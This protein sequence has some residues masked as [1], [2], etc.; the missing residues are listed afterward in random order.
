[1]TQ[2]GYDTARAADP[3][4]AGITARARAVRVLCQVLGDRR[5]LSEALERQP[6]RLVDARDQ[7]LC[8]ELCFG[9]LRWLPRLQWLHRKL[10]DGNHHQDT[11]V[12]RCVLYT[13]LYQI[14]HLQVPDHAAVSTSVELCRTL[15]Q[16]RAA[17]LLN[18]LLRRYLREQE[19][20]QQRMV[21]HETAL[22]AHPRW[23]LE[24][25]RQAWPDDWQTLIVENNQR[26][27][28]YLR[29]N[30]LRK[31][32][33][34][35]LDMLDRTGIQ[36]SP[37][38]HTPSALRLTGALPVAQLPGFAQGQCAVQDGSA[39]LTAELLPV[40]AGA[41]ML[42]ACAAPGG[43]TGLFLERWPDMAALVAIDRQ[44]HRVAK[45]IGNLQRLGHLKPGYPASGQN[46]RLAILQADLRCPETWWDGEAFD[47]ILLDAPCSGSGIIRRQPDIKNL[48]RARQLRQLI[49]TQQQLLQTCWGLL[50][51]GGRLLYATCSVLPAENSAQVAW[52]SGQQP[53]CVLQPIQAPWGRDTGFGTQLMTGHQGMDG[54]FYALLGKVPTGQTAA[55]PV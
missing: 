11:L 38:R 22:H 46:Q 3:Q 48:R 24:T 34:A 49:N 23:W 40:P 2:P 16:P 18:A 52:F 19:T 9:V 37:C 43:K 32:R 31:S 6:D 15:D 41:R 53:D 4:Q 13:G 8:K 51:P 7:A 36:A 10:R 5:K 35:F 28:L 33:P 1:M 17:K 29:V 20:M 42:D 30:C 26:P 21:Q 47:V 39:Q 14:D 27:P 55:R 45:L 25:L 44:A 12:L 54:F 50:K